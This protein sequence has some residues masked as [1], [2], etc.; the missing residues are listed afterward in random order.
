MKSKFLL[1]SA[2]LLAT[3]LFSSCSRTYSQDELDAIKESYESELA[4]A[5]N[6]ISSLQDT[7]AQSEITSDNSNND[8]I[9]IHRPSDM[10]DDIFSYAKYTFGICNK[11]LLDSFI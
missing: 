6:T 5:E 1:I 10:S 11:Y 2:L 4:E 8:V 7:E 9:T 3:C